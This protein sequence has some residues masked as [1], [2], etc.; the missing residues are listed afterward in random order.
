MFKF[1]NEKIRADFLNF[2][3][4]KDSSKWCNIIAW[5]TS[6]GKLENKE[7]LISFNDCLKPLCFKEI[8]DLYWNHKTYE[9]IVG[10]G[11][12]EDKGLG[13]YRVEKCLAKLSYD[14]DVNL[15]DI[16]FFYDSCCLIFGND[17][18]ES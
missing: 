16:D 15:Y 14:E 7:V 13:V 5:Q 17:I 6:E 3:D 2:L 12:F 4:L 10:I 9:I 18:D 11:K 1:S 8:I